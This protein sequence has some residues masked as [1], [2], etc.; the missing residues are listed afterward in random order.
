MSENK[1]TVEALALHGAFGLVG[2]LAMQKIVGAFSFFGAGAVSAGPILAGVATVA[3]SSLFVPVSCALCAVPLVIKL[4]GTIR[5]RYTLTEQDFEG[6]D[7]Y[8]AHLRKMAHSHWENKIQS[9]DTPQHQ[10]DTACES[11]RSYGEW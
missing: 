2:Y 1:L 7:W 3:G 6:S 9:H 4:M 10:Q 8:E 11:G 5:R